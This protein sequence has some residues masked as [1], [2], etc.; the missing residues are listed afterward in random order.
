[1]TLWLL[2]V[3]AGM[4]TG[5]LAGLLG[6]GGGGILVPVLLYIFT[7]EHFPPQHM[8]VVAVATT[9]AN[10]LFTSASSVLAHHRRGS[11]EWPVLKQ[12]A[13]GIIIGTL[14]GTVF[15]SHA[16]TRLLEAI[17]V[18]FLLLVSTQMLFGAK[19]RP[20]GHLPGPFGMSLA[21]LGIGG[22]CSLVGVGGAAITV[23][24]L[25]RSNMK[26]HHAIGTASAIGF[27]IALAG[28]A[29]YIVNGLHVAGLPAYSLGFIYLPALIGLTAAGMLAAP[30]GAKLAHRL[31]VA[32]LRRIFALMLYAI[33][34]KMAVNLFS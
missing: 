10:I 31:P 14:A 16:P 19:A 1:M 5:F 29:G 28:A 20:G 26:F 25:T 27:P 2:Y 22:F 7:K 15:A 30:W 23:P 6:I 18:V 4:F 32:R 8:F 24:F 9:F 17:F 3:V 11:V 21:G 34:I 13:P 12:I 33:A